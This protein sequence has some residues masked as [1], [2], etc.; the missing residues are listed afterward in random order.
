MTDV[1]DCYEFIYRHLAA[2][3]ANRASNPSWIERERQVVA[4]A[5]SAWASAHHVYRR[6]TVE[7]V[8]R[9]ETAALGHSDYATKLCLYV[10][11]F[12]CRVEARP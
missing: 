12:V 2:E 4:D 3:M 11:E 5:A 6:V 9:I 8:E 10:A 1:L 7:D